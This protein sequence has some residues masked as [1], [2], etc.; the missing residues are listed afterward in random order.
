LEPF[1]RARLA[2]GASATTINRSLEAVRTILNRAAHV[3]RDADGRPWLEGMPPLITMLP[4]T[5][6]Q[7][8]PITSE[9]YCLG[10][11]ESL[12]FADRSFDLVV[13]VTAFALSTTPAA[14]FARSLASHGSALPS[15]C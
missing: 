9:R 6:R 7:P 12:R 14:Q 15:V 8:Y 2:D 5:P 11:A 3:Y 4:E 10:A 1:V 13:S